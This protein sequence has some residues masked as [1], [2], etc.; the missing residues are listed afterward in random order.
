MSGF[1]AL[2]ATGSLKFFVIS[3]VFTNILIDIEILE[4]IVY[5]HFYFFIKHNIHSI[6]KKIG[7]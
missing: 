3:F 6:W 5:V 7:I 4:C 1:L 2:K